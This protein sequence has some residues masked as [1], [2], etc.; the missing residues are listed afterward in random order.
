MKITILSGGSGNDKLIRGLKSFY[1]DA[2]I[3]VVVNAYDNGKSTGV[4]RTITNTLGVSDIRKNHSRMYEATDCPHDQRLL[5]FYNERYN[6]FNHQAA[7]V[8]VANKLKD[9]GLDDLIKYANSFFS[10]PISIDYEYDNFS[11]ANII[12]SE[13]YSELGYEATNKY[14]CDLLG[15]DDF[16]ILNSFDNVYLKARTKNGNI[17][18]DEGDLVEF[19]THDDMII[20]TYYEPSITATLNDK[21]VK[22][23]KNCDLLVISTGTFWSSIFPT[24]QYGDMYKYINESTAKKVWAMNNKEDKDAYGISSLSFINF[25]E[26]LGVDLTDFTILENLDASDLLRLSSDNYNI[27]LAS[28]GNDNG[29]HDGLKYAKELLKIYYN[30]E[31]IDSYDQIIFDFDDTIWAR[32]YEKDKKLRTLSYDNFNKVNKLVYNNCKRPMIISGNLYES[33]YKKIRQVLGTN[34]EKINIDIWADAYAIKWYRGEIVN[35]IDDLIIPNY[36]VERVVTYLNTIGIEPITNDNDMDRISNI[37]VKPLQERERNILQAYLND[38]VF[39]QQDIKEALHAFK[40]GRTTIDIVTSNSDK[41]HVFNISELQD[42]KTLFIGDECDGGN[43][44]N[45]SEACT[46]SIHVSG[47]EETNMLLNLMMGE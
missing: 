29:K 15:I 18:E 4:C 17:I 31:N 30:L 47:V 14:F 42:K 23:I 7:R 46:N 9:W 33:L 10:R 38:Y 12:Y 45:I 3:K 1:K 35:I 27:V 2:D 39:K 44:S 19:A 43:D 20:D 25:V 6:M 5:E 28:M 36:I 26:Q 8:F 22:A 32:D 21:A 11:I 16:V 41:I 13:M 24:L 37:K 34:P 40:T